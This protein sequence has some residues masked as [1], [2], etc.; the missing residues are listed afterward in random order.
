MSKECIHFLGH[1]VCSEEQTSINRLTLTA[2]LPPLSHFLYVKIFSLKNQPAAVN[3][4]QVSLFL[5]M[6]SS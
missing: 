2:N 5:F 6:A 4:M 3:V 1:S